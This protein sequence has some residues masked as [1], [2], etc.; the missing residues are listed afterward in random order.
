MSRV[1]VFSLTYPPFVGG[2]EVAIDQIARRLPQY[3][4]TVFTARLRPDLP[5]RE[6]IGAVTVVRVGRG[7]RWDKY[8]YPWLATAAAVAA[9]TR[10]PFGLCWGMMGSWGGWAALKFKERFPQ[11]PYVLSEQSGDSEAFI[12]RR[13]WFWARRYRQIFRRADAVSAISRYLADRAKRY[14]AREVTVVPNGVDG[15]HF[16][17]AV[18]NVEREAWLR[19]LQLSGSES[20]VVTVSRLVAKN[21]VDDLITAVAQLNQRG[22][23]VTLVVAGTGEMEATLRRQAETLGI[24]PQVRFAGQVSHDQLP[25]LLSVAHV[26][27]R[28]S[29]TEG[30][31]NVFVEAMAAGLPV[32]ATP[33]GGIPDFMEHERNGLLVAPDDPAMLSTALSRAINERF[34]RE[35]LINSGRETARRYDW[36]HVA[37][38]MGDIFQSLARP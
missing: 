5:A 23:K 12:R 22:E 7:T 35:R 19:R 29:R 25:S 34:L 33:V 10:T 30:F 8:R 11:V 17:R 24:A 15:A 16:S 2:A 36:D 13:T 6:Q 37:R 31:G 26:F 38:Q 32:V 14:G 21:A 9:H 20:V 1:A 4:W 28:P 3:A 27:C 18:P